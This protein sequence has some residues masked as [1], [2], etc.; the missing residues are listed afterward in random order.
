VV[1]RHGCMG[2]GGH[3]LPKVS[4]GSTRPNPSEQPLKRPYSCFRGGPPT[5]QAACGHLL[6]F[7]TPQAVRLCFSLCKLLNETTASFGEV[8]NERERIVAVSKHRRIARGGHGLPKVST[9][10]A[11]PYPSMPCRRATLPT[12]RVACGRLPPFWTPHAIRLCV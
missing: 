12:E 2:R 11:M 4:L 5:E 10:P 9:R 8:G 1:S 6:S 7:W 3:G